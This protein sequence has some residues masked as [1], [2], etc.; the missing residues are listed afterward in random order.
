MLES[1]VKKNGNLNKLLDSALNKQIS[2]FGCGL[3]E[4]LAILDSLDSFIFYVV[5]SSDTAIKVNEELNKMGKNS[6]IYNPNFNYDSSTIYSYSKI[7]NVLNNILYGE[8]NALV[9]PVNALTYKIVAWK[10]GS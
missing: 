7:N 3:N 2:V 1:I 4:R 6:L 9:V 5:D 8:V 10:W